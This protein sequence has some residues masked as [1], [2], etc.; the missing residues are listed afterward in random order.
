MSRDRRILIWVGLGL[1]LI[2]LFPF[3]FALLAG[4]GDY[5]FGGFL[6]NPMDGN[7]YLAKM[8]QGYQGD[9]QYSLPYSAQVEAGAYLF[10]FYI[11]LG[12]VARVTGASL[13]LVFHV[14]RILSALIL[15]WALYRFFE[16]MKL[17]PTA[18]RIVL[19]L[20]VFGS[21][22]G[23]LGIILGAFTS[24]LWVAE[25]YPF[26]S[27]YSNPHFPLGLAL[28]VW[29]LTPRQGNMGIGEKGWLLGLAALMLAVISP[30]GV[31]ITLVVL[32]S[33][34]IWEVL[35]SWTWGK[36]WTALEVPE[37]VKRISLV[38]IGGGPVLAYYYWVVNTNPA[39]EAWNAQNLTP[40]PPIWDFLLS[41]SPVIWLAIPGAWWVYH[42]QNQ[43]QRI[44]MVWAGL[45][46]ILA[47]APSGLQ[48]RF[49]M[50]L[51]IPLAGL[52]IVG[53]SHLVSNN[54][55]RLS[56][57]SLILIF[58]AVPTNLVILLTSVYGIQTQDQQIYLT[59]N[60]AQAMAWISDNTPS[61]AVILSGPETGV[62]IPAHS[63]RRVIYGHPFETI[64]AGKMKMLVES[65][66]LGKLR[67]PDQSELKA[68]EYL[69]VG[70]REK[71]LGYKIE[72]A[73]GLSVYENE[74]VS[75]YLVEDNLAS[76]TLEK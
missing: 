30:F 19:V 33:M 57:L 36:G 69:F 28:I 68:A 21:G 25:A 67:D 38:V 27:A 15:V 34:A 11:F 46:V 54:P 43:A 24:D 29:L 5:H 31:A 17:E 66:F 6:I 3:V 65:F 76:F 72:A 73:E 16:E 22:L 32:S 9:W 18:Q 4:G 70:P 60:E 20:V 45:G 71:A 52:A 42:N 39:F 44:L 53:L 26:L 64:R 56:S 8:Y 14:A 50:G 12:Q 40:S 13:L 37:L 2:I 1:L 59:S 63:G 41:F 23:W 35:D 48:R 74:S 51:Y 75:V 47:Y 55:K 61:E 62:F 58:L 49:L 7:T 10:L